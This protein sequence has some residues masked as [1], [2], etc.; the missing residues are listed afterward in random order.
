MH[1]RTLPRSYAA[2]APKNGAVY[3]AEACPDNA[4]LRTEVESLIAA[5]GHKPGQDFM[6]Q[7]AFSLGIKMLSQEPEGKPNWPEN[8]S[9]LIRSS[10][11]LGKGGMGVKVLRSCAR[12]VPSTA[13]SHLIFFS[14]RVYRLHMV[15]KTTRKEA[16]AV[17]RLDDPNMC[18]VHGFE[19]HDGYAFIVMQRIDGETL[20]S[21]IRIG[22]LK[23]EQ[24]SRLAVQI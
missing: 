11:L 20:A 6:E 3:L 14:H 10:S 23:A 24:I 12:T 21:L 1:R 2:S 16:Q 19:E 9:D 15:K 22:T 7:P 5:F 8:R 18:A 4:L 17:A 13:K